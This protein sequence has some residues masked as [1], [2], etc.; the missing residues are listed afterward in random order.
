MEEAFGSVKEEKTDTLC[1]KNETVRHTINREK[2]TKA[3]AVEVEESDEEKE[4]LYK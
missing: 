4:V 2:E 1:M 3:E